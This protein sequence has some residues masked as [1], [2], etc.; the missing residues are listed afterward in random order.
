MESETEGASEMSET[1]RVRKNEKVRG[2][3]MSGTE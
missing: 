2:E 3:R 1:V